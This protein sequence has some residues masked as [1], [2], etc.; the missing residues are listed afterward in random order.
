MCVKL[1]EIHLQRYIDILCVHCVQPSCSC[2]KTFNPFDRKHLVN[3]PQ[4]CCSWRVYVTSQKYSAYAGYLLISSLSYR[5]SSAVRYYRRAHRP[6]WPWTD[7]ITVT[8]AVTSSSHHRPQVRARNAS[9]LK[10]TTFRWSAVTIIS[11]IR[12]KLMQPA[13][14]LR[15]SPPPSPRFPPI[16]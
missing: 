2:A 10:W 16:P 8:S 13:D 4:I 12:A 11:P 15:I 1:N 3:F 5:T 6:T 7:F 9:Q 14:A